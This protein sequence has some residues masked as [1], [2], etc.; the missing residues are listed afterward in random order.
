[1]VAREAIYWHFLS[2][3]KVIKGD[4]VKKCPGSLYEPLLVWAEKFLS[5][6]LL[7]LPDT[8]KVLWLIWQC[9]G[10]LWDTRQKTWSHFLK[11]TTPCWIVQPHFTMFGR[12]LSLYFK[13]L[14]WIFC[15]VLLDDLEITTVSCCTVF[16]FCW[17]FNF[18]L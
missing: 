15:L 17:F 6:G 9:K 10:F 3:R 4:I 18:K 5:I 1:M 11:H 2:L 12:I 8:L 7:N 13:F 14:V 16:K